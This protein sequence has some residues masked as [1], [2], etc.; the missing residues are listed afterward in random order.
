MESKDR[1]VLLVALVIVCLFISSFLPTYF[2][3]LFVA[4][5]GNI[6]IIS[7]WVSALL[8][9][10]F[11]GGRRWA[12]R[13]TLFMCGIAAFGLAVYILMSGFRDYKTFSHV[14]M[15]LLQLLCIGILR[16]AEVKAY[17]EYRSYQNG[18]IPTH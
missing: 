11:L 10:A 17:L 3:T 13:A 2:K 6:K 18:M 15:L 14:F 1:P 16:D 9:L 4:P 5:T 12:R 7:P 8:I